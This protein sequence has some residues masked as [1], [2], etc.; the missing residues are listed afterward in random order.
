VTAT[1]EI[2]IRIDGATYRGRAIELGSR[3]PAAAVASAIRGDDVAPWLEATCPRPGPVH[4]HVG[5]V[6]LSVPFSLRQALAAAARSRGETAP[7]RPALE[8]ARDRL[9]ELTPPETDVAAARRRVAEAGASETRLRERVATLRGRL[10][11]VRDAGGDEEPVQTEL[12]AAIGELAEVETERIAAEQALEMGEREARTARDRRE[13][14]LRLEDRIANLERDARRSLAA[15]VYEEFAAA[16][17]VLPGSA[18]AGD[19]PGEFEGE[20]LTAMLAVARVA[21][22]SAPL[23]LDSGVGGFDSAAAAA[24]ALDAPVVR[25]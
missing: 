24:D 22:V 13:Q 7:Q 6:A 9:D 18:A 12:R 11:A 5:H 14:R 15:T 4:D 10:Q 21:D 20:T 8:A 1:S 3:L 16:T 19:E 23:V 17:A 25:L 2:A